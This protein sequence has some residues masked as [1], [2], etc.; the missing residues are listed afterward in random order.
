M[1]DEHGAFM[2]SG[3][4]DDTVFRKG[5]CVIRLEPGTVAGG[6]AFSSGGP[7]IHA[8]ANHI[9]IGA[10]GVSVNS[11]GQLVITTDGGIA[12]ICDVNVTADEY[13]V[14]IGVAGGPSW[15]PTTTTIVV[16]QNGSV[17]DLTDQADWNIVAASTAN[18]WVG[19]EAPV[20]RGIGE[21]S[22]AQQCLDLINDNIL[23]RIA[24]LEGN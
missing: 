4:N 19:W 23:P 17:L 5:G 21:P 16:S 15:G 6:G 11:L 9:S 24:A 7:R 8:D 20:V 2:D 12:P 3:F 13:L 1:A 18:F 14:G 10:T 22:L